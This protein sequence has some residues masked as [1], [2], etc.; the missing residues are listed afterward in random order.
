M[1]KIFTEHRKLVFLY[2]VVALALLLLS[3]VFQSKPLPLLFSLVLLFGVF[4]NSI[5]LRSGQL[6][7]SL[8]SAI[9]VIMT[10]NESF[11]GEVILNSSF[12]LFYVV[13]F[14]RW[15]KTN[16]RINTIS[17]LH[18]LLIEAFV[19]IFTPLYYLLLSS[20]NTS[21]ILLN[22]ISTTVTCLA[23]FCTVRKTWQ[24]F[25]FWI[26]ISLIQILL[27]LTT[28]SESDLSNLPIIM[29]NVFLFSINIYN[30]TV[31]RRKYLLQEKQKT[32]TS[33]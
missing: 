2:S 32:D 20:I 23:V 14:I 30:L 24:Q 33:E 4:F 13:S 16:F 28:F 29:V 15:K 8:S 19:V 5:F 27:W 10:F 1:K 11:Y 9:L 22:S 6:L 3:F 26:S 21:Q 17:R 31:W 12:I 7:F 18:F 25:I